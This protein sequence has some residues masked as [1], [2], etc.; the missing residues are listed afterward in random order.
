MK[1]TTFIVIAGILAAG[2]TAGAQT[3][4][5]GVPN[6]A[7]TSLN[8]QWQYLVDIREAGYSTRTPFYK[9]LI[10]RSDSELIEYK[11]T[12]QQVL[13]VPG[14]WNSQ[15]E[16]LDLY[17]GLVWYKRD[18]T[19]AVHPGR[20]LFLYFGAANY[21]AE[22]WLNGQSLGRHEGGFT[23]FQFEVTGKVQDGSNLLVVAVN[24]RRAADAVPALQYD[25]WNYGGLTGDVLLIETLETFIDQARVGLVKGSLT[26]AEV[27]LELDGPAKAGKTVTVMVPE[28]SFKR[29]ISTDAAG[30]AVFRFTGRF[31]L[32]SPSDPH[33]YDVAFSMDEET[34]RDRVGFRSIEAKGERILLN[35]RPVF[36]RGIC[37]HEEVPQRRSRANGEADARMLLGWAR[38]LGCNFVRM[39][40]YPYHESFPRLADE[41][42]LLVWEEIP[43][44]QRIDFESPKTLDVAR[45]MLGE[46]I[47]R[48]ANR[49]SV[50]IWSVGNETPIM[51]ARTKFLTTLAED[52]RRADGTRLVSAALY[53]GGYRDGVVTIDDPLSTALDVVSVNEYIGWYYPWQG[54]AKDNR[55]RVSVPKP[56]LMTEF[57]GE[58][59]YG[60]PGRADALNSWGEEY[61]AEL[62]RRQLEMLARIPSLCG[63]APWILADF[64]SPV[65][66][67]LTYQNGWNRKGLISDR[68]QKKKAWGVMAE[69]YRQKAREEAETR[70]VLK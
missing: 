66:S 26:E 62:Y 7:V 41:M 27:S 70:K 3:F 69:F 44:Y 22:V 52:A 47:R 42:G 6:R 10:P 21:K 63:T 16:R 18:F 24:D 40:H 1:R 9:N 19:Y 17:E 39:A 45:N 15:S 59:L 57:G 31:R 28:L 64:R 8:G 34:L 14:D 67:Q 49:A 20:R 11:F 32:W 46:L 68:G 43:V 65:R 4:M 25:W 53:F 13:D 12:D 48:D 23:P 37:M 56:L 5:T 36:L 55:W 58:A 54:A 60:N 61:Q 29:T 2:A 50:I 33:L 30:K 51:P 38:E 35:G